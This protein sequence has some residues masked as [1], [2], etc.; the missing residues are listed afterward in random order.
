MAPPRSHRADFIQR[1]TLREATSWVTKRPKALT[2][3]QHK[4]LR[5]QLKRVQFLE[6][7]YA[8]SSKVNIA[9]ILRKWKK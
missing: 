1:F 5:E 4:A 8:D 3:A 7:D 9:G 2:G 6:P